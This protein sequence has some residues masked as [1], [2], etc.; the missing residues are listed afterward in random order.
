[1]SL[2][3]RKRNME[4]RVQTDIRKEYRV[5]KEY[6]TS[7]IKKHVSFVKK[8]DK[9]SRLKYP[10]KYAKKK[11]TKEHPELEEGEVSEEDNS[12]SSAENP[13]PLC[14]FFPRNKCLFGTSCHFKHPTKMG[15]GNYFM[16]ERLKLPQ[17]AAP[18]LSSYCEAPPQPWLAPTVQQD[19]F[20]NNLYDLKHLMHNGD[21]RAKP[22]K[23]WVEFNDLDTDPYYSQQLPA[24]S[25]SLEPKQEETLHISKSFDSDSSTLGYSSTT[26]SL[27][28]S[29]ASSMGRSRK[30]HRGQST[31]GILKKRLWHASNHHKHHLLSSSSSSLSESSSTESSEQ[32]L[33]SGRLKR[34]RK[35]TSCRAYRT[36]TSSN[37][38]RNSRCKYLESKLKVIEAKIYRKMARRK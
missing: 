25:T 13:L 23:P 22:N 26:N 10:T 28:S 18:R 3:Y 38:H 5:H 30:R 7:R 16:F 17:A 2:L 12:S 29:S 14:R 6:S 21:Y 4:R 1:M 37:R 36:Q 11:E 33:S 35:T 31:S 34:Y 20:E 32:S 8:L 19:T 27:T 9:E 15:M 24:I